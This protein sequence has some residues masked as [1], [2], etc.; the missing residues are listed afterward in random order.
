MHHPAT[1]ARCAE[2]PPCSAPPAQ[3]ADPHDAETVAARR[4]MVAALDT[5]APLAPEVRNALLALPLEVLIPRGY[6]RRNPDGEE[7][8][9]WQLLDGSHP[10]DREEWLATLYGGGS[11]RIQRNGETLSAQRRGTVTGG[12]ITGLSSTLSMTTA[13]LGRLGLAPGLRFLD[14]GAGAGVTGALAC[15]VCGPEQ[16][17][18]LEHDPH[19]CAGLEERLGDL[20]YQPRVVAGDALA[21]WPLDEPV[22]RAL[23]GFALPCVPTAWLEHLAPG[24]RL[25]VTISTSTPSWPALAEVTRTP[26]GRIEALLHGVAEGHR[27]VHGLEWLNAR[28]LRAQISGAHGREGVTT[29]APPPRTAY[30]FWTAAN[31][32]VPG[33]VRTGGQ[34]QLTLLAP[35]EESW[36]VVRPGPSGT[37]RTESGGPR[38]IWAE[39]EAAHARWVWAGQP[40]SYRL[41]ISTSGAQHVLSGLGGAVLEWHLPTGALTPGGLARGRW[42]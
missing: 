5:G 40:S 42:S 30:G 8:G 41:D 20:G 4:A 12:R 25:L 21:P 6:V 33:L 27:P 10:D 15:A 31:Y 18:L 7:P 37:W 35:D 32:L 13:M 23:G 22:D 38:E 17:T 1:P 2:A 39:V 3:A 24:G 19:L 14:L 16:V 29:L 34:G 36:V 26:G 9:T 28:I 11:I